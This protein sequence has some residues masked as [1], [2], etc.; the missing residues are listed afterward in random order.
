M[1][2]VRGLRARLRDV[3]IAHLNLDSASN[4]KILIGEEAQIVDNITDDIMGEMN[5]YIEDIEESS[6]SKHI[7]DLN[8]LRREKNN[9]EEELTKEIT[10]LKIALDCA[11]S[12]ITHSKAVNSLECKL[13]KSHKDVKLLKKLN[14]A[15]Q[16]IIE[17]LI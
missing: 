16:D 6:S 3:I 13:A 9:R 1:D 7:E 5:G 12:G 4:A 8:K 11:N 2:N 15:Q 10:K 17:E 14:K